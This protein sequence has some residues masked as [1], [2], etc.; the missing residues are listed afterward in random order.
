MSIA[1]LISSIR[2]LTCVCCHLCRSATGQA[3]AH[4]FLGRGNTWWQRRRRRHQGGPSSPA[5]LTCQ[6][7]SL[8]PCCGIQPPWGRNESATPYSRG[9]QITHKLPRAL[10]CTGNVCC[11][12]GFRSLVQQPCSAEL[13]LCRLWVACAWHI[14]RVCQWVSLP[15]RPAPQLQVTRTVE[16]SQSASSCSCTSA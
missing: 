16:S 12:H 4:L 10:Q 9:S 15:M 13:L 6:V 5:G 1:V 7:L 8:G 14:A 3:Q 2:V 11:Q